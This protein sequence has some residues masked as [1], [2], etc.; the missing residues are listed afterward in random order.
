MTGILLLCA[1]DVVAADQ[2]SGFPKEPLMERLQGI[3]RLK[4]VFISF[5]GEMVKNLTVQPL[6]VEGKSADELIAQSLR[7]TALSYVKVNDNRYAIVRKKADEQPAPAP[8]QTAAKGK[9]TLSGTVVDKDGFP[10]PGATVIISGTQLGTSTD[11]KGHYTLELAA[12]TVGVDISCISYQKMSVSDVQIIAGKTTP[13]DVVLQDATTE[14]DVVVVTATYNKA[15]ANGLYAKQKARTVMS[16]GISADLIKKTSDNNVAQVLGRVSGVTIDNGK[17]VIVRGLGERYNNVQ[18]NGSSLPSTEPNRRNFSFDIIPTALIDNVTIAKTFTP[19]MP[20]EFTGGLVEVNTLAVPEERIIQL[21]V[22]TGFNTNSTGKTFRSTERLNG[23][24]LFGNSRDWYGNAWKSDV[25]NGILGVYEQLSEADRK[26]VNEMDASVPNHWGFRNFKG[27]PTQN[28]AITVGLPF[29]LGNDNKLGV[30]ASATYR[31]EETTETLEEAHY[32]RGDSLT[33]GNRYKFVSAVGAVANVG[34]ERPGHKV[35]WRNLFNNRF[36]H[37]NMERAIHSTDGTVGS[38][39]STLAEEY[40]VPLI[41]RI[42]QTQLTGE[43]ELPMGFVFS[44]NA[45]YSDM[46]RTSP[47]DLY[48]RGIVKGEIEEGNDDYLVEWQYPRSGNNLGEGFMLYSNLEEKKKNIGANLEYPFEVYGNK[49]KLKAGYLGN[50]RDAD[51]KQEYVHTMTDKNNAGFGTSQ[52]GKSLHDIYDSQN[53]LDGNIYL[54][55]AGDLADKDYYN[56]KQRIHSAYLMGEFTFWRKLHINGGVRMEAGTTKS[57]T[58]YE[59]FANNGKPTDTLIVNK[60]TDWLPAVTA[61]YNVTDNINF[62]LAYSET[63]AR[64][65]FREMTIG[66]YYNVDDRMYV[67]S[68]GGLKQ[69]YIKNVDFRFEWYPQLG[70]VISVSAFYKKFKDPVELLSKTMAE[71]GQYEMLSMNLESA[72]VKGLELNVRKSLGFF[73]PGS[74]LQDIYLQGNASLIKG[75]VKYDMKKIIEQFGGTLVK[76]ENDRDRPLQGLVPYTVNVGLSYSGKHLGAAINYGRAGRKLV[77]AGVAERYDEYEA[78][79]DVLDL[80]ISTR[81]LKNRLEVK[82]NASD[83]LNQAYIV[84]RNCGYK[85]VD[86]SVDGFED[87][88]GDMNYNEGD[89]ILGKSKRGTSYSLSVSYKF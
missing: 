89:W 9:G 50:F 34:W 7:S 45:D 49:Q 74:F 78:P 53:Y 10:V 28:Y 85:N 27:A 69:T 58:M 38:E 5:E 73:A 40:S 21:S 13:L 25:S 41:N 19:D 56:G 88:T 59:N 33:V 17:Y 62:R 29:D 64:P 14:L 44:W 22:G 66:K 35:T 11:L 32:R 72:T 26:T 63:L 83:L 31:H 18:L 87:R 16:D 15:S 54:T 71:K 42:W 6:A 51:Y 46:K 75:N 39:S 4:K 2:Q 84:Y 76:G 36:T 67:R 48:G 82:A 30:I 68:W 37:T 77:M 70:E 86:A 65:D 23:D 79:R 60:K 52:A 43:H 81:F 57:A 1:A 20:G 8:Q 47:E 80:Q 55:T 24:Y 12:R 3:E 61:I